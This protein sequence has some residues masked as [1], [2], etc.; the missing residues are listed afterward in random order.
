MKKNIQTTLIALL[1]LLPLGM[2]A[3]SVVTKNLYEGTQ[4]LN[5]DFETWADEEGNA[6]AEPRYWHSFESASGALAGSAKGK[7]KKSETKKGGQ[8][9]CQLKSSSILGV[10][11][12]GTMTTGRLNAASISAT[13]PVN[14]ASLDISSTATDNYGDPFYALLNSCPDSLVLWVQF[15]QGTAN[16]SHPYATVSAAIT[17]GT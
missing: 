10:I 16:A 11:A 14:H 12:N 7:I 5:S 2:Q 6:K 1:A 4:I 17:N 15:S 13:D 3:Q 9:S 8:Y